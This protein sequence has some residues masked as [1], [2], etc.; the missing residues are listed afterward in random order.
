MITGFGEAKVKQFGK[1]FLDIIKAYARQ[2]A[3]YSTTLLKKPKRERQS[4]AVRKAFKGDTYFESF[5]LYQQGKSIQDI[6]EERNLKV[7]T[8]ETH[9]SRYIRLGEI[10]IADIMDKQKIQ[11]IE[12]VLKDYTNGP[13]T[14]IKVLLGDDISYGDIRLVMAALGKEYKGT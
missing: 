14:P 6:A 2:N 1:E 9:L 8:I 13:I 4:D 12:N 11:T 10:N 3:L 7:A 5:R